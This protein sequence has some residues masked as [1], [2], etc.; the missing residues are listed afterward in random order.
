MFVSTFAMKLK[1]ANFESHWN[2]LVF[3]DQSKII[4]D[5]N[6]PNEKCLILFH[7]EKLHLKLS[8]IKKPPWYYFRVGLFKNFCENS[9]LR[10]DV[11]Y[12]RSSKRF[13]KI[14]RTKLIPESR[15]NKVAG[16]KACNLLKRDSSV[17]VFLWILWHY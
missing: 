10:A 4:S 14:H 5:L 13:H 2:I 6:M 3:W 12:K 16:L 9:F 7:R 11:L 17:N 1:D 8:K 15:F